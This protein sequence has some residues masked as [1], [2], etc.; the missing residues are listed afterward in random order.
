MTAVELLVSKIASKIDDKYYSNQQDITEYVE[1]AK[2]LEKQQIIDA[3]MARMDITDKEAVAKIIGEE[4]YTSTYGSKGND[5]HIVDTNEMIS[6]QT[7]I[8]DEEIEKGA[9]N[10]CIKNVDEEA[11]AWHDIFVTSAKWYREQLKKK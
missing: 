3:Y 9:I 5:E 10:F 2:Q 11:M 8:S 6:S 1:Q 4:Y 7:E